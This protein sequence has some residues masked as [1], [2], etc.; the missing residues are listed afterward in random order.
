MSPLLIG[1]RGGRRGGGGAF[2]AFEV[3][4]VLAGV[5]AVEGVAVGAKIRDEVGWQLEGD[6]LDAEG[7]LAASCAGVSPPA[8]VL[9]SRSVSRESAWVVAAASV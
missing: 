4:A 9:S 6:E 1:S 3:V 2:D 5:G 7:A 8:A